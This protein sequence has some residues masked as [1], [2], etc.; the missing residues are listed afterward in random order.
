VD[1]VN[2]LAAP[3]VFWQGK[4]VLV[5]GGSGFLGTH[6]LEALN[7]HGVTNVAAPRSSECDLRDRSQSRAMLADCQPNVVIHL[8]A[9]VGGIAANMA[10]PG[11]FFYEN[12]MMGTQL[13]EESRLA[14]VGKFVAVG[15][16]CAYPKF[17]PVPFREDGLWDGYPEETNAPYG[18]A[19]KMLLVQLQAYR[20]QYGFKGI[21]LLPV[22]LY[23]PGDNIDPQKSHVIPALIAKFLEAKRTASPTVTCWGTGAASREFLYVRDCARAVVAATERYNSPDPVNLGSGQEIP[24]ADLAQ[25]I[26]DLVD[27]Q[28]RIVWDSSR[29]DGQP[30]RCLD[31]SRAK[32]EFGFQAETDFEEGLRTTIAWYQREHAAPAAVAA[33]TSEADSV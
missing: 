7:A 1:D 13:I 24:V 11:R 30:R 15:T 12:L 16:V 19:K 27:Y 32:N 28:G 25:K 9:C 3:P 22:N 18:L 21:Y 20:A 8:A 17:A 29:P 26:A 4:R 14:G 10:E 6:L 33:G 31:V 23:G 2:D 5:T